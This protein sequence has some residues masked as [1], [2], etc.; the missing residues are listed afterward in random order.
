MT[1]APVSAGLGSLKKNKAAE[2]LLGLPDTKK[3]KADWRDV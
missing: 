3:V 2:A 1:A